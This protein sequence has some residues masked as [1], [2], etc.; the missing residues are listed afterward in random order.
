MIRTGLPSGPGAIAPGAKAWTGFWGP[1]GG[2]GGGRGGAPAIGSGGTLIA[3]PLA[4]KNC[5]VGRL[6]STRSIL[7]TPL[8][9]GA[10]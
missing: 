5:C 2:G 1:V 3:C 8:N 4:A 9:I 6:G 7:F 10:G